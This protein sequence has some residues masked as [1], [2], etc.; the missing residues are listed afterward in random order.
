M[1]IYDSSR[2]LAAQLIEKFKNDNQVTLERS[3]QIDDGGGGLEYVWAVVGAP[4]DAAV[5]PASGG[6]SVKA[7][8]LDYNMTHKIYATFAAANTVTTNDRF[9][10]RGKYFAIHSTKNIAEADAAFAFDCEEGVAT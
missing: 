6:E 10:F 5:I 8:R 9:I 4:F 1:T 7:D 3:T 2:T